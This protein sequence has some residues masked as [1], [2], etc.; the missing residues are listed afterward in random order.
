MRFNSMLNKIL[1]FCFIIN[2]PCF[3]WDLYDYIVVG[4]RDIFI[5]TALISLTLFYIIDIPQR[6]DMYKKHKT[7]WY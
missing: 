1:N 6:I 4:D 2:I 5:Y 3:I 7:I